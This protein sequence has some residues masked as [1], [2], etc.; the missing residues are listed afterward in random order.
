VRHSVHSR[1]VGNK[2]LNDAERLAADPPFRLINSRRI[3]ECC[4]D[5]D[6]AL[7]RDRAADQGRE[8]NPADGVE[9]RDAGAGRVSRQL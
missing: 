2:D 3:W 5:L 4:A 9:T 7:I 8:S 6:L 1:W